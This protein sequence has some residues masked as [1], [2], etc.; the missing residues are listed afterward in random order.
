MNRLDNRVVINPSAVRRQE[1]P[2]LGAQRSGG[3]A[4]RN[5]RGGFQ[6]AFCGTAKAASPPSQVPPRSGYRACRPSTSSGLAIG[7]A[8]LTSCRTGRERPLRTP[9]LRDA[10]RCRAESSGRVF[11]PCERKPD[12][13]PPPTSRS[14][15]AAHAGERRHSARPRAVSKKNHRTAGPKPVRDYRNRVVDEHTRLPWCAAATTHD[16]WPPMRPAAVSC[17]RSAARPRCGCGGCAASL[18]RIGAR[19][20]PPRAAWSRRCRTTPRW[21]ARDRG[22]K[23]HWVRRRERREVQETET[24][25]DDPSV[26]ELGLARAPRGGMGCETGSGE[27]ES[28]AV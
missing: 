24:Q 5:R 4:R 2:A 25:R 13:P 9:R 18:S 27:M 26:E 19:R 15:R 28:P 20:A 22:R 10:R 12:S 7:G 1:R 11:E 14:A 21:T 23:R 6:E 17:R 16:A 8:A 3:S